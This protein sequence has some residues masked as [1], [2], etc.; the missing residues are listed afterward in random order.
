M[1][2]FWY[3]NIRIL[4]DS[5]YLLDVIPNKKY[6][7]IRNLNAITRLSIYFSIIYYLMNKDSNVF[8]LPLIVCVI[9]VII[10][11]NIEKIMMNEL[12][13]DMNKLNNLE[14]KIE[15][16][17]ENNKRLPTINNPLMNF[18]LVSHDDKEALNTENPAV[19][20]M[21]EDNLNYNAFK[22]QSDPFTREHTHT[23]FYTMPVTTAMND[24]EG[25]ARWCYTNDSSC[26]AGNLMDC[27]KKRGTTGGTGGQGGKN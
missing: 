20:K 18:N 12:S 1:T 22:N 7:M 14:K 2:N 10:Y 13:S 15:K 6:D 23:R 16:K 9:T 24:Q 17:L 3:N 27:D 19:Q 5:N 8:C 26:K 11:K 25:F 4:I 21:V